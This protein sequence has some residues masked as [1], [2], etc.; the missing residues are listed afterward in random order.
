[1]ED[2]EKDGALEGAKLSYEH[3]TTQM[4]KLGADVPSKSKDHFDLLL[5]TYSFFSELKDL[6]L[7]PKGSLVSFGAKVNEI[8]SQIDRNKTKLDIYL[9]E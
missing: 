5:E 2:L 1:M 3:I 7:E 9:A 6:T 8:S 4:K